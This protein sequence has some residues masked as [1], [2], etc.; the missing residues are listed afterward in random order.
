MCSRLFIVFGHLLV[1][2]SW[3]VGSSLGS[4]ILSSV[5]EVVVVRLKA[6]FS[7]S[8]DIGEVLAGA[9][10][11]HVHLFVADVVKSFNTVDRGILD[12]VLSSLG[13]PGWFRHAYFEYHAH[14]RL[15]F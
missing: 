3:I 1:W 9:A 12:R 2:V 11:S 14:V 4:L 13:L 6:W 7:S 5:L 15:R 10:D 8:L